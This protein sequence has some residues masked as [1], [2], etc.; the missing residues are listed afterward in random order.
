[1]NMD[2]AMKY[3]GPAAD[4]LYGGSDFGSRELLD[5]ALNVTLWAEYVERHSADDFPLPE[6]MRDL[7]RQLAGPYGHTVLRAY[8]IKYGIRSS[9]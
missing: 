2:D 5:T 1:M 4:N 9:S 3:W 8:Q 7:L 6:P